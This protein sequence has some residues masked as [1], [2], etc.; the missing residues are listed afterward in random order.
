MEAAP[1]VSEEVET[2]LPDGEVDGNE[3]DA[4]PACVM[5]QDYDYEAV[6]GDSALATRGAEGVTDEDV[7]LRNAD[8]VLR[9]ALVILLLYVF[10][11]D[12]QRARE[13]IARMAPGVV[14]GVTPT[15]AAAAAAIDR[16]D[17]SLRLA[18]VIAV[19][20]AALQTGT[21]D[22]RTRWG[23]RRLAAVCRLPWSRVAAGERVLALSLLSKTQAQLSAAGKTSSTRWLKVGA[24]VTV[25]AGLL[26]VTG[27]LAAPLLAAAVG[28]LFSATATLA[29]GVGL[30]TVATAVATTAATV[31]GVLTVPVIVALFG[32]TGA[33]VGGKK[34]YNRTAGVDEFTCGHVAPDLEE[35]P[36]WVVQKPEPLLGCRKNAMGIAVPVAS[37]AV[38]AYNIINKVKATTGH[39]AMVSV[40][41]RGCGGGRALRLV[42]FYL[43]A[44]EWTYKPPQ[45]IPSGTSGQLV[46]MKKWYGV[47][48]AGCAV[49]ALGQEDTE[50]TA[51]AVP[52]RVLVVA[53]SHPLVGG[54]SLRAAVAQRDD[55]A[56]AADLS[57]LLSWCLSH[58]LRSISIPAGVLCDGADAC[59]L[60]V[61][62]SE[63][64]EVLL[65]SDRD[66]SACDVGCCD[67]FESPS[68]R[69]QIIS[70]LASHN[71]SITL[72]LHN[73]TT[74][75]LMYVADHMAFGQISAAY[76]LPFSVPPGT[77]LVSGGHNKALMPTPVSG[78]IVYALEGTVFAIDRAVQGAPPTQEGGAKVSKFFKKITGGAGGRGGGS[79]GAT[80]GEDGECYVAIWFSSRGEVGGAV[81][82]QQ[83]PPREAD[84]GK[85]LS[86]LKAGEE[87][88]CPTCEP[89]PTLS[90]R[91]SDDKRAALFYLRENAP[92]V[93]RALPAQPPP[94]AAPPSPAAAL[95]DLDPV[96]VSEVAAEALDVTIGIS[97]FTLHLDPRATVDKLPALLWSGKL[98]WYA[99]F[100]DELQAKFG[101][102]L[103]EN[104]VN[105]QNVSSAASWSAQK[106]FEK[107]TKTALASNPTWAASTLGGVSSGY[108]AVAGVSSAIAVPLTVLMVADVVDATYV[109]LKKK[110]KGAG[111]ILADMLRKD[112]PQGSRPVS[113]VGFGVGANAIFHAMVELE[114]QGAVGVVESVYLLG[115]TVSAS[116]TNWGR[117]RRVVAGRVVN[118]YSER[119]WFISFLHRALSIKLAEVAGLARVAVRGVENVCV[120]HL[121]NCTGDYAERL[122]D[123]LAAIP[124]YPDERT[125]YQGNVARLGHGTVLPLSAAA[126]A[127][128]DEPGPFC[129]PRT[130]AEP[131][132]PHL[133]AKAEHPA[134]RAFDVV[135]GTGTNA[136]YL[137]VFVENKT[138]AYA[139][140]PRADD[141]RIAEGSWEVAPALQ[142][143]PPGHGTSF[144]VSGRGAAWDAVYDV[145]ARRGALPQCAAANAA[146]FTVGHL[147]LSARHPYVSGEPVIGCE[148]ASLAPGAEG[149]GFAL[150]LPAE[151]M[152]PALVGTR[153][154]EF[155]VTGTI[156]VD[157]TTSDP[158]PVRRLLVRFSRQGGRLEITFGDHDTAMN[159]AAPEAA[160][161]PCAAQVAGLEDWTDELRRL[162]AEVSDAGG[163]GVGVVVRNEL[164]SPLTLCGVTVRSGEFV[165]AAAPPAGIP[166][167]AAGVM[168][169]S[170][171]S[172]L[173]KRGF[174]GCLSYTVSSQTV[175]VVAVGSPG[176]LGGQARLHAALVPLADME[177]SAGEGAVDRVL[178]GLQPLRSNAELKYED[179]T[180]VLTWRLMDGVAA[181]HDAEVTLS[182]VV[183]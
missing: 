26:A 36:P 52:E 137:A 87:I 84:L 24:G 173:L 167:T 129:A 114:K 72:A 101:S 151:R 175:L 144:S 64:G 174:L 113:L 170:P 66:A 89:L 38:S 164:D 22:A 124:S 70:S 105:R 146:P 148:L 96:R 49:Y 117:V 183:A 94:G 4:G 91:R 142:P 136:S 97:G 75:N 127:Q 116:D 150:P 86:R 90:W 149:Q 109:L 31:S 177:A 16:I 166:P 42:D 58:P 131:L 2:L 102:Y 112:K 32:I 9:E 3:G 161:A 163:V 180:Y 54:C 108:L 153:S 143:V 118:V 141:L 1:P 126:T 115:S 125:F 61:S 128:D 44:G 40:T 5:L 25:G 121:V 8:A 78:L 169:A 7:D 172:G 51:S 18:L 155:D 34:V 145:V 157:P 69:A 120:N 103:S 160:K 15:R 20:G 104:A 132:V 19:V 41:Y 23:V 14:A 21:Y 110:A 59:T 55:V 6:V 100:E 83:T 82:V 79:G 111:A 176:M 39:F 135:A 30:T 45:V 47:A 50:Q 147:I 81:F 48:V 35:V 80:A 156:H 154:L 76:P 178:D 57:G 33:H 67:V 93:V 28:T 85:L 98:G 158:V 63:D 53:F 106:G 62:S 123:V 77:C 10:P 139:L 12:P 13:I 119:D 165:D 11:C 27:G 71:A 162:A 133:A 130:Y 56:A 159:A 99:S 171:S 152:T 92:A 107:G 168:V 68:L 181:K 60:S 17:P 95:R 88:G 73:F 46:A 37:R 182:R 179:E 134:R 43:E 29:A 122:S 65:A 138:Q 140:V 74:H